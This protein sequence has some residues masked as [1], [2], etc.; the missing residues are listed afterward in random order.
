MPPLAEPPR[1]VEHLEEFLEEHVQGHVGPPGTHPTIVGNLVV[2]VIALIPQN[3]L[4]DLDGIIVPM[5]LD[6]L[7][8]DLEVLLYDVVE[9]PDQ[10]RPVSIGS[11]ERAGGQDRVRDLHVEHRQYAERDKVLLVVAT[12][13]G[14]KH[15]TRVVQ[16]LRVRTNS[17]M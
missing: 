14:L 12:Q 10:A 9:L 15:G 1:A 3:E 13:E 7:V 6:W 11:Q 17:R 16:E 2:Q 4:A 8:G 5:R